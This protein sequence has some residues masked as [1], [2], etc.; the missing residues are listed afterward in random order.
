MKIPIDINIK[1]ERIFSDPLVLGGESRT[2][3]DQ[4]TVSGFMKKTKNGLTLEYSEDSDKVTT[5]ICAFNDETV[6]L[7]RVGPLNSHMIF[8]DGKAHTCICD[9]GFF[10]LQMRI[11][12]KKLSNSLSLDGGRLD[13]DYTV[14]IV[15]NLAEQNR[16]SV[17]VAPDKSI[18]KS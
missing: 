14:E 9:T 1:S 12:T 15:G 8:A 13:I 16:L 5:T 17:S 3:T 4:F 2:E 7:S 11:Y 6:A 10:P 18:I